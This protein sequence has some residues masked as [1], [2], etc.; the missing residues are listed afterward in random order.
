MLEFRRQG[1]RWCVVLLCVSLSFLGFFAVRRSSAQEEGLVGG[2]V[3]VVALGSCRKLLGCLL[4]PNPQE[5]SLSCA[6]DIRMLVV[7][8][9]LVLCQGVML[10][11]LCLLSFFSRS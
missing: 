7:R 5:R 11:A 3:F 6:H 1:R 2:L 4:F 10:L 9:R 8:R